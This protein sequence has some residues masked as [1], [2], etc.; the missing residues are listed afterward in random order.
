MGERHSTGEPCPS[1]RQCLSHITEQKKR[2]WRYAIRVCC[3]APLANIDSSIGKKLAKMIVSPAIAE[4]KFQ[5]LTFQFT[6]QA[7]GQIKASP[8]SLEPSYKAVQ[9]THKPISR[10]DAGRLSQALDFG[11]RGAQ[12]II[13]RIQPLR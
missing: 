10:S 4:A 1:A 7:C 6:N 5:H 8:L 12:L 3:N 9:S 13:R 11:D 2:R